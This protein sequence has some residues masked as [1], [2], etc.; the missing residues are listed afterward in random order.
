LQLATRQSPGFEDAFIAESRFLIWFLIRGLTLRI[1]LFFQMRFPLLTHIYGSIPTEPIF[2][3]VR[4]L[5]FLSVKFFPRSDLD[6]LNIPCFYSARK[7]NPF[8]QRLPQFFHIA[9][10]RKSAMDKAFR[11]HWNCQLFSMQRPAARPTMCD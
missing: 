4:R 5:D 2:R 7:Q 10:P 6:E 1:F 8:F 9:A 11:L 3:H